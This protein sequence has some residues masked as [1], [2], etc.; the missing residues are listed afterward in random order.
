MKYTASGEGVAEDPRATTATEVQ[1]L[2]GLSVDEAYA[3]GSSV[4]IALPHLAYQPICADLLEP[5]SQWPFWGATVLRCE[6][7][8]AGFVEAA[9]AGIVNQFLEMC[10]GRP[11][12]KYLVLIDTDEGVDMQA[13][14][15]LAQWGRPVVSGVV[16]GWNPNRG[17]YASF[18]IDDP[19]GIARFPS[20]NKTG[21]MPSQG[22]MRAK[23]VGGG[24]VCIRKDVLETI[25]ANGEVPFK[26]SEKEALHNCKSGI[27]AKGEDIKF[28]EQAEEAGFDIWVD[29]SVHATHYKTIPLRWPNANI[30]HG[31]NPSDWNVSEKDFTY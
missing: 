17:I 27:I 9:R 29:L 30:D 4:A 11:N 6:I 21:R 20:V 1:G 22:L 2:L 15:K 14:F 13:P 31:L 16:C 26:L 19:N 7:P 24:L 8:H 25:I 23:R 5:A 12:I 18:M 28:C 3:L 10:K